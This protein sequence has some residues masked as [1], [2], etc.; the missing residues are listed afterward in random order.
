MVSTGCRQ[1]PT[2]PNVH[3]ENRK[4]QE[5]S[6]ESMTNVAAI[7]VFEPGDL[8]VAPVANVSVKARNLPTVSGAMIAS[9]ISSATSSTPP[10]FQNV[11]DKWMADPSSLT[12]ATRVSAGDNLKDERSGSV[13]L[14]TYCSS[15]SILELSSM[16]N[17]DLKILV[18]DIYPWTSSTD[19]L[20]LSR[21]V[22]ICTLLLLPYNR[23]LFII[24]QISKAP[25]G[26]LTPL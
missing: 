16:F 26:L 2:P 4:L 13:Y 19:P 11:Q 14:A 5:G 21:N 15:C 1:Y 6:A 3:D 20:F 8:P 17:G 24:F 10:W 25:S 9:Q 23:T 22:R 12:F 18:F 7:K